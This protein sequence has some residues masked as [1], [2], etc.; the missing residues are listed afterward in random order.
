MSLRNQDPTSM[1]I[2][3]GFNIVYPEFTVVTPQTGYNYSVRCL[4]VSEVNRL[5]TSAT[6]PSKATDIINKTV[7]EAVVERPPHI[8]TYE[9]FIANTTLR[10]REALLYGLYVTTFGDDREFRATCD[11]C[12]DERDLKVKM[13]N[14]FSITPYPESDAMINTYTMDKISGDITEKDPEM[15]RLEAIKRAEGLAEQAEAEGV[16]AEELNSAAAA[17]MN[18][19]GLPEEAKQQMLASQQAKKTSVRVDNSGAQLKSIVNVE[20]PVVL[21]VSK[22]TCV[23]H[24]PS[25]GDEMSILSNVPFLQKKQTELINETLL[26]KRFEVYDKE[27]NSLI[28]VVQNREDILQGYQ[29]LPNPDKR[30]IYEVFRDRFAEYGIQLKTKWD[31]LRCDTENT[32]ELDIASQFFRMVNFS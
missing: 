24:Q 27:S 28:Q 10:D 21:P 19:P 26:I 5:K 23:I 25:I 13:S 18:D 29:Q 3:T 14:M 9:D 7:W 31:C 11:G 30:K 2:F 12:G 16:N 32:L 15:E 17:I 20:I 1:G 4:T 8:K 22:I 6:T